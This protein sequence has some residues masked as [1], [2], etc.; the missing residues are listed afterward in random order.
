VADV[1]LVTFFPA[2]LYQGDSYIFH[3]SKL[4]ASIIAKQNPSFDLNKDGRI[5]KAEFKEYI[6]SYFCTKYDYK[7]KTNLMPWV[8]LLIGGGLAVLLW[9]KKKSKL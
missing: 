1:Y 8:A 6:Y 4:S 7:K 2:A 9:R 3:T 5:T